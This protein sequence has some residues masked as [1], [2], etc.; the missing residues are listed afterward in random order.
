[1]LLFYRWNTFNIS[2]VIWPWWRWSGCWRFFFVDSI[3]R[4]SLS[5]SLSPKENECHFFYSMFFLLFE[6]YLA[7]RLHILALLLKTIICDWY[8]Q[9]HNIE[10]FFGKFV[11]F[12][13]ICTCCF[14]S[15]LLFFWSSSF[16]IFMCNICTF[17]T[18][19]IHFLASSSSMKME[20]KSNFFV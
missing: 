13:S 2:F 9:V 7:F 17:E 10:K 6:Y 15:L 16:W 3:G 8:C 4:L 12:S 11:F 20:R 1:M 14:F 18:K 5:L 19:W